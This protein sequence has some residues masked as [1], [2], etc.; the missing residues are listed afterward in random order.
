MIAITGTGVVSPLGVG[1]DS[2]LRRLKAG[3]SSIRKLDP[4]FRI[5]VGAQ[6]DKQPDP[7]IEEQLR[8][9]LDPVAQFSVM[10]AREAIER[11]DLSI[12]DDAR[13]GAIMG[14][15]ICG[16]ETIDAA[17]HKLY[18]ENGRVHPFAIPKIMPTAP[19]S[20]ITMALGIKGPS[21]CTTS[22]CASSAHAIITGA[23]WLEAGLA[24]AI[25]VGGAEAPF[26]YGLLQGWRAMRVIAR[27]TCRPFSIDRR[28][29]VLGEGS[30]ALVLERL[31][32]AEAR[33]ANILAVLQG[34]NANAD[35]GDIVKPDQASITRAIAGAVD[36]SGLSVS[37]IGHINGHATGT[38]MN[39]QME[40][41]A[42]ADIFGPHRPWVSGTKGATGHTLGAAGALE[43]LI[44]VHG[45][46]EGW[47]PPSVNRL[48]SDPDCADINVTPATALEIPHDSVISS[49]F[50]FGGLNAVLVFSRH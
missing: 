31:P 11:A 20:A 37:D 16:I 39:D 27:D 44:C 2:F 1:V 13:I 40:S 50:A 22:A 46:A 26:A 24:D 38:P 6:F 33:G 49:S 32:D 5:P 29:M 18:A 10:A 43:A 14:I 9:L 21:F 4:S 36:N 3:E 19:A 28:G 8:F 48:G 35:A 12:E 7:N 25:V 45:L 30:A 42:I 47:V 23:L 17:Y 34:Y 15:G 41:Q